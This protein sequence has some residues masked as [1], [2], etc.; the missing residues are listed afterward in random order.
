MDDYPAPGHVEPGGPALR[1][2]VEADGCPVEITKLS[3]GDLDNNVYVLRDVASGRA[4]LI[5]AA[6]DPERILA[7][8]S[9]APVEAIVTTHGHW[10]HHRALSEVARATQASPIHHPLDAAGI[11]HAA[12][13]DAEHGLTVRFGDAEVTLLHTPG[14]TP[15]SI[16]VLLGG[17]H[18]FSGDTLFPGGPGRTTTPEQFA[19]IMDSVERRIFEVLPDDTRVHPGHGDDTT[20]G[21]ERASLPEWRARGW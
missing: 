4:L 18:L 6:A 5:D 7:E 15:G 20:L 1:W 12:A 14:H 17:R 21:A 13:R 8:V 19:E 11:P 3:V 16:C 9:D 10:D 2:S